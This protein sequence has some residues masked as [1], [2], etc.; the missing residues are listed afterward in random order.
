MGR[1]VT[2]LTAGGSRRHSPTGLSRWLAIGLGGALVLALI[3]AQAVRANDHTADLSALTLVNSADDAAIT[4]TPGFSAAETEYTA[5]VLDAVKQAT[6][7]ATPAET[8]HEADISPDDAD[9]DTEGHQVDLG[10]GDTEITIVVDSGATTKTYMVTVTRVAA[11][12]ASLTALS[13]SAG[14]LDPEFDSGTTSYTASVPND[15]DDSDATIQSAITVTVTAVTGASIGLI[16]PDSD[17]TSN[18]ATATVDLT[19]G[20]PTLITVTVVAADG[21]T[22]QNYTVTATRAASDDADLSALTLTGA[23]LVETFAAD[24][25]EYTSSVATDVEQITVAGTANN[26]E[27]EVSYSP[28]D[29]VPDDDDDT[30]TE[31]AGHQV[32]LAVGETVI[33]VTVTAGDGSTQDYTITV[34][35]AAP[36]PSDDA[37]LS[38]L[39][40]SGGLALSPAFDAQEM[41]YTVSAPFDLD[42]TAAD[43]QNQVTVTATADAGGS[44]PAITPAD[45]DTDEAGH[46]VD[47]NVGT[48]VIRASVTEGSVTNTYTITVTR[49]ANN[50][51]SLSALSL[52][53]DIELSPMFASGR[54]SYTASVPND[55][56]ADAADVQNQITVTATAVAGAS[57][58][59]ITPDNDAD[60]SNG[61]TID[62]AVG[63]TMI[64]VTAV[65]ADGT[66]QRDYTVTVTRAE[67]DD[68]TLSALELSGGITLVPA[69]AADE[70]EYTAEVANTVEDADLTATA[71]NAEAEVAISP[72]D[73]DDET[74][75]VHDVDFAVGD[76]VITVTVTAE[77][78]STQDYTITV[79]RA[80]LDKTSVSTLSAFSLSGITLAP[81]FADSETSYTASV[82][83]YVTSTTVTAT[84]TDAN[85]GAMVTITPADADA[86]TDGHQVNLDLGENTI[87]AIV[88]SSDGTTI[89]TYKATVI[90]AY[91]GATLTELSLSGVDL[92]PAF[93]AD[94][95]SYS[96]SVASD[97]TETTVAFK[98]VAGATTSVEMAD[99]T[100]IADNNGGEDGL[101]A[102]LAEGANTVNVVVTSSDGTA[103]TTYSVSVF[104]V[105]AVAHLTALSLGDDVALS[106]AFAAGSTSYMADVDYATMQVTVASTPVTDATV[107]IQDA[108]GMA[109]EDADDATDGHQVN[110]ELGANTINVVVS[111]G[112]PAVMSTYTVMVN[113]GA[114]TDATLSDLSLSGITLDPAFDSATTSYTA[115][116][117]NEVAST[118]VMATATHADATVAGTGAVDLAE[119]G[120]T[121][122]VTVTAADGSTMMTYT[123]VVARAVLVHDSVPVFSP[124]SASVALAAGGGD[125]S[126]QVPA[127]TGGDGNLV[128]TSD[129]A[130]PLSFDAATRMV[131]GTVT[132]S[133]TVVV[134]ATDEDGDSG[135]YTLVITVPEIETV[136]EEVEVEVPGPTVVHTR[137]VTRTETVEVEVPAPPNV[138]GGSMT[139]MAALVDGRVLI[140]RHD[141]G[142][143]LVIDIGGFIRDASLGQTYQVVQRMDGMIVRQWVSPNSPLVY[144]IPWSIVNTQ[145]TVPVG[146]IMAIPLDDQSGSEGQLV[147][148]FDGSGDDRIFSYA[149]MGQW[150]HVPDIATFQQLGFYWCDVTAADSAFFD[151]VNVG[152]PHPAS[153]D[154]ST[155][156][157]YPSC[158]TG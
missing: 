23:S 26:S 3:L 135:T 146:V 9:G 56:D 151:R 124:A 63:D 156:D 75:D 125:V 102:A 64:T 112:D 158:S 27:A 29:A 13:L 14:E 149:G 111:G 61:A 39:S 89:T 152:P 45:A 49:F 62:L 19:V 143:S 50:D 118:M 60:A 132:A 128:Y 100:A 148:R 58:G 17:G 107:A 71:N 101:Q 65:A 121:I 95:T 141:G 68:A 4:L 70:L 7:T 94:M 73:A 69:F 147:R 142:P 120:N 131:S 31:D 113:R 85:T 150:R 1:D 88:T 76:T 82:Q 114:S 145:F 41:A 105:H 47:L 67:S 53:D 11:D 43:V 66:T 46:Q 83:Q 108:D 38:A 103:R 28:A 32:D 81:T 51:A 54:T 137:T 35:R 116:V 90:R 129:A 72:E 22:Q 52:G 25:T 21:T 2:Y 87:S 122:M 77:D 96:G 126:H 15:T 144:Q 33:T 74:M 20:T 99:G 57:V 44:T 79:T 140:T 119:G 110:L 5:I 91:G 10:I 136:T 98:A 134:T 42:T 6:V 59:L 80:A 106:P 24:T 123:V 97:V 130:A 117:A 86:A 8:D 139:A 34:T 133:A 37:T 93:S 115:N 154:M 40:L 12:D 48:T 155:R 30:T 109:I 153:M 92:S 127:A 16:T 18:D 78:G 84:A 36:A 104:R 157:D 138:I 55:L